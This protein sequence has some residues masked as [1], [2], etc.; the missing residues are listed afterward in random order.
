M[1]IARAHLVDASVTRWYHC[2]TRCVRRAFYRSLPP[3]HVQSTS[4]RVAFQQ[5]NVQPA[6]VEHYDPREDGHA[7]GRLGVDER[8]V[9]RLGVYGDQAVERDR[10]R[11]DRIIQAQQPGMVAAGVFRRDDD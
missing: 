1:T 8:G 2:V 5:G 6:L 11:D 3:G 10:V 7:L 4:T 9:F